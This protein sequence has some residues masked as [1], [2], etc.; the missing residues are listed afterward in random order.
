MSA[1]VVIPSIDESPQTHLQKKE[2][3]KTDRV[4]IAGLPGGMQSGRSSVAIIAE[5]VDGKSYAFIEMSMVNF[6]RAAVVLHS[7]YEKEWREQGV[8]LEVTPAP[9][10]EH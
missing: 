7:R 10:G 3:L 6:I 9:P 8:I 4:A 2:V 5:T 1:L